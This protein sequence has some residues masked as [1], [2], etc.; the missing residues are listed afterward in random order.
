MNI[1]LILFICV[2]GLN[3]AFALCQFD[4]NYGVDHCPDTPNSLNH[5]YKYQ[6]NRYI[7][8]LN[9]DHGPY[10]PHPSYMPIYNFGNPYWGVMNYPYINN[11]SRGYYVPYYQDWDHLRQRTKVL[12]PSTHSN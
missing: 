8:M 4:T 7:M 1:F 10:R 6:L 11:S 12:M 3:E 9:G 5:S 2:L